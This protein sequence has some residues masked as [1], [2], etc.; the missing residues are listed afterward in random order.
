MVGVR[1]LFPAVVW[2]SWFGHHYDL[3]SDDEPLAND[4][5]RGIDDSA[6]GS[7]DSALEALANSPEDLMCH[8]FFCSHAHASPSV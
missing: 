6:A 5:L 4:D 2:R 7:P 3:F 1:S 8:D